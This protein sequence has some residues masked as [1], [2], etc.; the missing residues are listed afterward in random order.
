LPSPSYTNAA[1]A[2]PL[3]LARRASTRA[4]PNVLGVVGQ[5]VGKLRR[6]YIE[7]WEVFRDFPG[8]VDPWF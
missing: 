7:T 3:T 2:A 4:Q 6:T 5:G 8:L 1:L